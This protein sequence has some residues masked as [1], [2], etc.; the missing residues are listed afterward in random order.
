[1]AST[2]S[3]LKIELIGT[4][5]QAGTWGNTTNINLGTALQEAITGSADV[6]FSSGDVTLTLTNSNA[7]QIGR[8]LRLNLTGTSGGAR[9]LILGAEMQVEKLY[10]INNTLL[11][12]VTVKNTTGTGIAVP[13][14]KTM[15]VF[16]NGTNVVD[17]IDNLPSGATVGGVAIST[18]SGTVTSVDVSG[19]T[20]GLTTS[21]GPVTSSGTITIA[22]T[23]AVA[24]GG[25]GITSLGTGVGTA[26]G[27]NTGS[28]GAFVVN[29]GALGTPSSGTLTNATGLPI[30]TGVSGLGTNVATF[31]G[32]PSSANL[33]AAVT[34]ETGSGSL[35]FATSPTLVTP[36]LGTPSSGTLTN[37][38]FPTLNQNTTGSAATFTSTSQNSQFNSVG[39]G[40]AASGTTG[41]IRATNNVTA[42]YS[43]RRLKTSITPISDA[44]SKMCSIHGVTFQ[45]ND[46][47]AKY[48]YTDK[49]VQVGVIAQEVK[50]VLPQAVVAAPFDIGQNK[51]GSEYSISGENYLTVQYEK[52]VPLLIEAIK[53]LKVEVDQLKNSL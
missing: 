14:G 10:L 53:E 19:G 42:F 1:M 43:D 49:K 29:G 24:N 12:A 16:N 45:S 39:V 25:T 9:N 41:E 31:L 35:V 22:G 8:N 4:G 37:C 17:A 51:D 15:F 28:A 38:T 21:G 47:A 40:T 18:A 27:V 23:L 32:T 20:T 50:E 26:L 13:A 34:D 6:A 36:A 33:A 46:T 30:G 44:L 2:Y 7:A 52:L 3:D 5:E 48:G 11:D